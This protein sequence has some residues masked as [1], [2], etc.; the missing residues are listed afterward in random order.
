MAR[1]DCGIVKQSIPQWQ[2]AHKPMNAKERTFFIDILSINSL[3]FSYNQRVYYNVLH[4]I[5]DFDSSRGKSRWSV[6]SPF[7]RMCVFFSAQSTTQNSK[8]KN[9]IHF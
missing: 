2:I 1:P 8:H 4:E 7:V 6:L 9:L 5:G 3:F